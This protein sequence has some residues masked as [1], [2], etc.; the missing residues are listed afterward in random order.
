M[1][2]KISTLL[3]AVAVSAFTVFPAAASESVPD[4]GAQIGDSWISNG[5]HYSV[6]YEP[7]EDRISTDS[8]YKI[9][10][11]SQGIKFCED[12]NQGGLNATQIFPPT[13]GEFSAF[14]TC[15]GNGGSV[16]IDTV[17]RYPSHQIFWS[18]NPKLSIMTAFSGE[19]E[20]E[21]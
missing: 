19:L 13:P 20:I 6:V 17:D 21:T 8:T 14:K 4:N 18:V 11:G 5:F 10:E 7:P 9:A 12:E 1:K 15:S 16:E 2:K 3:L